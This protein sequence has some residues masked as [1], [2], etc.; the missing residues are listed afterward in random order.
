MGKTPPIFIVWDPANQ[1]VQ[2]IHV[3]GVEAA[4]AQLAKH[5]RGRPHEEVVPHQWE[6]LEA[7]PVA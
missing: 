7:R 3:D 6:I 4:Q 5:D 1:T 2:G